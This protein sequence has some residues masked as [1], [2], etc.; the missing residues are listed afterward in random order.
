MTAEKKRR[1]KE[2]EE[3]EEERKDPSWNIHE[4]QQK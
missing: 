3:E 1:R 4:F 2:E